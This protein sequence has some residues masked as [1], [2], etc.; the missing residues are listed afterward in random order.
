M[1]QLDEITFN[2]VDIYINTMWQV[3]LCGIASNQAFY[4]RILGLKIIQEKEG[5]GVLRS[6]NGGFDIQVIFYQINMRDTMRT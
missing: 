5:Y 2:K 3:N 4:T 6:T 1:L